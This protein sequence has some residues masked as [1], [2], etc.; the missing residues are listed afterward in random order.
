MCDGDGDQK[1]VFEFNLRV[2]EHRIKGVV[3]QGGEGGG[4]TCTV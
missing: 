1:K 4:G 2:V 3:N